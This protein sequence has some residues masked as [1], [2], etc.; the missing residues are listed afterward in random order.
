[1]VNSYMQNAGKV[2][3][4]LTALFSILIMGTLLAA[5]LLTPFVYSGLSQAFGALPWPFSRVYDRV[6]MVAAAIILLALR[7][8]FAFAEVGALYM[9]GSLRYRV[10][11]LIGGAAAALSCTAVFIPHLVGT[12]KLVW[13]DQTGANIIMYTLSVV[14]SAL[15]IALIEESFFRGFVFMRL[16]KSLPWPAAASV[17]S[18]FFA[19][20]H[21]V[22]PVKEFHYDAFSIMAGFHYI[23]L[24]GEQM[25]RPGVLMASVGLFLVGTVLC[26]ALKRTHSLYLCLGLHA[27]WVVFLKSTFAALSLADPSAANDM[28]RRFYLLAQPAGWCSVLAVFAILLLAGL[29]AERLRAWQ[30]VSNRK[31]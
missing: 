23:A 30:T 13:R 9:R 27:G 5:S 25:L 24:V 17:S 16:C 31:I 18:I 3:L 15:L 11:A 1:M 26:Y 14:P 22:R 8:E 7:R 2:Q 20:V 6:A 28:G 29:S 12:G 10:A 21:F 4:S 19:L